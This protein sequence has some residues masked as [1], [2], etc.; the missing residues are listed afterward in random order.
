MQKFV[1][2]AV[3]V[4]CLLAGG[5]YIVTAQ[6][7]PTVTPS[8]PTPRDCHF[9]IPWDVRAA[10]RAVLLDQCTGNTWRFDDGWDTSAGEYV[11]PYT[12]RPIQRQ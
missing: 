5:S 11:R 9:E 6:E 7:T 3:V 4:A 12:W 1:L 2:V 8:I 10:G